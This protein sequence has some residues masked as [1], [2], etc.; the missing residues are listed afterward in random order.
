M[1]PGKYYF[2]VW[3]EESIAPTHGLKYY[4]DVYE[5][6]KVLLQ[7]M[8]SKKYCFD[9]WTQVLQSGHLRDQRVNTSESEVL[10]VNLNI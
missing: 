7:R 3:A 1:N 2:N 10:R 6:R 4:F 5:P 8:D 9:A